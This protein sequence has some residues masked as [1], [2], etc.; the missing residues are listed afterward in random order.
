MKQVELG[1]NNDEYVEIKS[2][3]SENDVIVL[4]PLVSSSS[5]SSST[6]TQG[7]GGFGIGGMGGGMEMGGP[8]DRIGGN[9]SGTRSSNRSSS[10]NKN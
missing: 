9:I 8:P 7:I 3:L 1:I 10:S 2:G 4:P 6:K 5:S